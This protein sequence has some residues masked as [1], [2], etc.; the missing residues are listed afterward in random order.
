MKRIMPKRKDRAAFKRDVKRGHSTL[1]RGLVRGG[2]R[3]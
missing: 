1:C 2:P 3:I